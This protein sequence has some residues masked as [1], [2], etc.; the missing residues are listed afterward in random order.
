MTT[1][2]FLAVLAAAL[3]HAAWNAVIKGRGGDGYSAMVVLGLGHAVGGLIGLFFVTFPRE[4]IVWAVIALSVTIH[5]GYKIALVRAY[6]VGDFS[7]VYPL[8]R[9]T[10]PLLT[11]LFGYLV[12]AEAVTP[13]AALGILVL[14]VGIMAMG[15]VS[16]ASPDRTAVL[17]A[18]FVSL[19][20]CGYTLTD[21]MGGRLAETPHSYI[22]YMYIFDGL[23][24]MV[25]FRWFF[26]TKVTLVKRIDW[27]YGLFAGVASLIAYW[28][29]IWA[30]TKAP[31]GSV[32]ALRETSVLAA[33]LISI[34]ILGE[35]VTRQ[36]ALAS[37]LIVAG[38][39]L[40]KLS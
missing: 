8:A 40:I 20:I 12:L 7:L 11:T 26:G 3:L 30:M 14:A 36:R 34:L 9:G 33:V 17:A 18:L 24:T 13:I 25:A 15:Y 5:V 38:A 39:I 4:P 19:F 27:A 16:K 6:R 29:V 31:I 32:A 35:K 37:F 10:A 28:I 2:I 22:V 21:G 23:M 1:G